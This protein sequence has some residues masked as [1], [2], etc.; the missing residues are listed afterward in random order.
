MCVCLYVFMHVKWHAC[1]GQKTAFGVLLFYLYVGSGNQSQ[2][3]S[4]R[5]QALDPLNHLSVSPL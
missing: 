2:A 4:L 3:V 1:R 5:S